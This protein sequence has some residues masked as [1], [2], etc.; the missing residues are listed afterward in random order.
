MKI[1]LQHLVPTPLKDR[2]LKKQKDVWN[3]ELSFDSSN[4]TKIVAP[5]GTGKTTLM[6]MM[7]G[8]RNDYEGKILYNDIDIKSISLNDM[9]SIRQYQLS[10]VFQDLRL[11]PQLTAKENIELKRTMQTPFYNEEVIEEMAEVLGITHILHQQ[12][13]KC[14]YGEQQRIAIIRALMQP[15][16]LLLLDEPFSHLDNENTKKAAKLIAQECAARNAGFV[17]TDLDEDTR[18]EYSKVLML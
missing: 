11:F 12:T 16:E 7:Y 18:F 9:A 8:L 3:N 5:S 14:S 13:V 15:F 10:V 4:Y 2:I 17:I 1:S 6:N